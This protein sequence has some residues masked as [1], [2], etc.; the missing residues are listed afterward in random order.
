MVSY[1][2]Q[3]YLIYERASGQLAELL[4]PESRRP[5]HAEAGV[6]P[7]AFWRGQE[8]YHGTSGAT[9]DE[10]TIQMMGAMDKMQSEMT[11]MRM[12]GN[13]DQD[14]LA[15]MVPHHESAVEMAHVYLEKGRDPQLRKLAEQ[16]IRSQH[17]EI[18]YMRSR[19]PEAGAEHPV[20][21]H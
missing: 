21:H 5:A 10:A 3:H 13:I 6:A 1:S 9:D 2:G 8:H 15:M 7:G 14:F 12:T 17:E 18:R 20:A 4:R 19:L 16:I 11:G